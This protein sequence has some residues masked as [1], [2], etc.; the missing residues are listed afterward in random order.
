M[1]SISYLQIYCILFIYALW[2]LTFVVKTFFCKMK[3]L[4]A[5]NKLY[6]ARQYSG[7]F[8]VESDSP[9]KPWFFVRMSL[10]YSGMWLRYWKGKD[11]ITY[12]DCTLTHNLQQATDSPPLHS[13]RIRKSQSAVMT[14]VAFPFT[15][16]H[17]SSNRSRNWKIEWIG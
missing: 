3:T 1:C 10:S 11:L 4:P 14:K 5:W 2:M 12:T 15:P 13:S 16:S 8:T 7:V 9:S 6:F 17:S